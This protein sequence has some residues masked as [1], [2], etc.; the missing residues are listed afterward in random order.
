MINRFQIGRKVWSVLQEYAAPTSK[1]PLRK[2]VKLSR[3]HPKHRAASREMFDSCVKSEA[4]IHQ[5]LR[6]LDERLR[7]IND[8]QNM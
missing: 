6:E 5:R 4:R 8:L 1:M 3:R 7:K 2:F